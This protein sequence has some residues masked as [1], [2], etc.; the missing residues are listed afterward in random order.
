MHYLTPP[1][2]LLDTAG[3][4]NDLMKIIFFAIGVAV[5]GMLLK[6]KKGQWGDSLSTVGIIVIAVVGLALGYLV[7]NG[8][9]ETVGKTLWN[10]I[11]KTDI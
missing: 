10:A 4:Q 6:A 11:F 5:V 7:L 1:A 3:L 9:A 2:D 8:Q